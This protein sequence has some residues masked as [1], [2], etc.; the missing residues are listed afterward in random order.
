MESEL[1]VLRMENTKIENGWGNAICRREELEM[2]V[3]PGWPGK[4]T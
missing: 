1:D 2:S 4:L 3:T